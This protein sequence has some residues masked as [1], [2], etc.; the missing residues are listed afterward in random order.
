MPYASPS[1][2]RPDAR[3]RGYDSAWARLRA[4]HLAAHPACVACGRAGQHV[5][6]I[7]TVRQ[8][9]ARRLD[10][11][12]LQTLC[13]MH[14]SIL[15]NAHDVERRAPDGKPMPSGQVDRFG[16]HLDPSHPWFDPEIT[17]DVGPGGLKA[18]AIEANQRARRRRS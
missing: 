13:A 5:D 7:V 2:N 12:N 15:T 11:A 18:A 10:P 3:R 17:P 16:R 14:H 8:D 9:P 1:G 4:A 6:H